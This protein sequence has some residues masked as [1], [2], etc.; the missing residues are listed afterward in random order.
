MN[1]NVIALCITALMLIGCTKVVHRPIVVHEGIFKPS[2]Y[3]SYQEISY[4]SKPNNDNKS[5]NCGIMEFI[6]YRG[7]EF[8]EVIGI[9]AEET[10]TSTSLGPL[11]LKTETVCK[12]R[13][14]GVVFKK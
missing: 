11:V 12:Y 4:S 6:D 1:K 13:G 8:D 10:T 5:E 9:R 3:A 14:Y 2:D 7:G